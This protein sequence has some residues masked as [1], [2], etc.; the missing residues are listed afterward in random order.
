MIWALRL[1]TILKG[2]NFHGAAQLFLKARTD[3]RE[4]GFSI[5]ACSAS[6][7]PLNVKFRIIFYCLLISLGNIPSVYYEA[8]F[9]TYPAKLS[10]PQVTL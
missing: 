7:L 5:S 4:A 1:K 8:V 10:R 2:L 3:R 6:S 9:P